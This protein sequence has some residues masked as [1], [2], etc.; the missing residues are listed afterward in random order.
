MF[1]LKIPTC[2]T[3]AKGVGRTQSAVIL[4]KLV[5]LLRSGPTQ[6][7]TALKLDSPVS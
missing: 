3:A 6:A 5:S 4:A 7:L 1:S 2:T